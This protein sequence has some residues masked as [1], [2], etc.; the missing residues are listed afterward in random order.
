V[1][2][3]VGAYIQKYELEIHCVQHVIDGGDG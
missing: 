1:I 2:D 3:D